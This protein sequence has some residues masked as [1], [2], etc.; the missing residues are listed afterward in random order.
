[1]ATSYT[2]NGITFSNVSKGVGLTNKY[3][4]IDNG[5]FTRE[6]STVY[7]DGITPF[8]NAIEIDWNGANLGSYIINSTAQLLSYMSNISEKN[9][10][11]RKS[12]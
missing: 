7:Q 8:V 9:N 1:M 11:L 2:Y 5:D 4:H 12:D 10:K 3:G 6:N